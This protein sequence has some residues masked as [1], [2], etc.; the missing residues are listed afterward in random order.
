M[1][2]TKLSNQTTIYDISKDEIMGSFNKDKVI[3]KKDHAPESKVHDGN[4][5]AQGSL[6]NKKGK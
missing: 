4:Q 3:K 5:R 6:F 2:S 1:N